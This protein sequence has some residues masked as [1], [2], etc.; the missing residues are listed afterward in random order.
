MISLSG[1]FVCKRAQREEVKSREWKSIGIYPSDC[2]QVVS[3]KP[4]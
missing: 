1:K 2:H 3:P 4:L